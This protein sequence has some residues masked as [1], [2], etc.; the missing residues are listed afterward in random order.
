MCY[1]KNVIGNAVKQSPIQ[2]FVHFK[3]AN[4]HLG[5]QNNGRTMFLCTFVVAYKNGC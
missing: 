2:L 3:K 5:N 1:M 4:A